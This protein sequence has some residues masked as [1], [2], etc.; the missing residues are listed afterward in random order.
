MRAIGAASIAFVAMSAANAAD[1]TAPEKGARISGD[2]ASDQASAVGSNEDQFHALF[3]GWQRQDAVGTQAMAVP[4]SK[5]LNTATFTSGFGV[6]SD[7]FRGS[8]AMH[9]G[10]DLAA[11]TGTAVYATADGVVDH[12]S[13]EGGYGNMVE[14]NHG[15]GLETR[16]GHLSRILVHDGQTV[17]RGDLIALV[18]STGRSTGPHLH[19]EVRMDGHA[20][21]PIPYLQASDYVVAMQQRANTVAQGGPDDVDGGQD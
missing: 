6:R 3:T 16:F 19:Y 4:S 12:A 15:K 11:P 8:A 13:W 21:N 20:V 10:I 2:V 14:I 17:H 9:A 1:V 5:P 7:P 18:G